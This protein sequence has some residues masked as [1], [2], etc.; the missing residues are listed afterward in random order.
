MKALQ[1]YKNA[2]YAWDEEMIVLSAVGGGDLRVPKSLHPN[3]GPYS[4]HMFRM[5]IR[6]DHADA[7][8]WYGARGPRGIPS[9]AK[10]PAVLSASRSCS[11]SGQRATPRMK[12]LAAW[13]LPPQPS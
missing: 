9:C 4:T 13:R 8:R 11:A 1:W 10:R 12:G 2:G 7:V 5:A 3:G 6:L